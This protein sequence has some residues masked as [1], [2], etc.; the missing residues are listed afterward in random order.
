M[1]TILS[2][3]GFDSSAGGKPS[4]IYNNKFYSIPIPEAGSGIFYKDL[5]F[6]KDN[7]YL[8]VMRDLGITFFSEAHLDPDLRRDILA[9]RTDDKN[10][11]PAFGQDDNSQSI[12]ESSKIDI[13]DIFLFFGWFDECNFIDDSFKYINYPK[14]EAKTFHSIFSYFEVGEKINL[15]NSNSKIPLWANAHPHVRN[16]QFYAPNNCLYISSERLTKDS[17]MPGAGIFSAAKYKEG[18]KLSAENATRSVWD[19]Q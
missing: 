11:I 17:S 2:R 14:N 12:L 13:G 9:N 1:K 5:I 6:D 16:N 4:I 19:L 8:G 18:L 15:S 7:N 3:K 10:W